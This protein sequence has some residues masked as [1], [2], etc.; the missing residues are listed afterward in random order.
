[1]SRNDGDGGGISFGA[2]L[3]LLFVT[4]KLVKVITWPWWVVFLP[5]LVPMAFMVIM[6]AVAAV[7][8]PRRK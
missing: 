2:A 6:V 3:L 4:L 5:A 8:S 1:M 7:V